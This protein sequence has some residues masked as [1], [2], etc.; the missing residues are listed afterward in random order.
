MSSGRKDARRCAPSRID[1]AGDGKSVAPGVAGKAA[2]C[3]R[4]DTG[5]L[6]DHAEAEFPWLDWLRRLAHS[7]DGRARGT[8]AAPGHQLVH[9]WPRSRDDGFDASVREVSHPPSDAETLGFAS[10]GFAEK[11]ALH[12]PGDEQMA[13]SHGH[14]KDSLP[15]KSSAPLAADGARATLG[16][17][18]FLRS[19]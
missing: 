1:N 7:L 2:V 8:V 13:G 4:A 10:H 17:L 16:A 9:S 14:S 18:P 15:K 6:A 3:I 12:L 5:F 19:G 11:D